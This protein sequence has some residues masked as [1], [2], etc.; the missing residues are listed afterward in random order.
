[1]HA[2]MKIDAVNQVLNNSICPEEIE[3]G[4]TA[5]YQ[6]I[7]DNMKLPITLQ[8]MECMN[9]L[10]WVMKSLD[11]PSLYYRNRSEKVIAAMKTDLRPEFNNT[12]FQFP[13]WMRHN[14][15]CSC[16]VCSHPLILPIAFE[17]IHS[18]VGDDNPRL[19]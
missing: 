1:M 7:M 13:E 14:L 16:Y 5:N 4:D 9:D 15:S 10:K 19:S 3:D 18:Q 17:F 12:Q 6:K 2:Q 8:R 11:I